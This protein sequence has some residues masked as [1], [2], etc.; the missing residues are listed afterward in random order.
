MR[1]AQ[2]ARI[3]LG[4]AGNRVLVRWRVWSHVGRGYRPAAQCCGSFLDA[5][6]AGRTAELG[7]V[8]SLD[9]TTLRGDILDPRR[10]AERFRAP[11][12]MIGPAGRESHLTQHDAEKDW[13]IAGPRPDG[14]GFQL[15]DRARESADLH[16]M[17]PFARRF[18]PLSPRAG[19]QERRRRGATD[20][21]SAER[22]IGDC[23]ASSAARAAVR[24]AVPCPS[25]NQSYTGRNT[26]CASG[27]R[28]V[29]ASRFASAIA[30]RSSNDFACWS[31]AYAIAFRNR[32]RR[33][34]YRRRCAAARLW[35]GAARRCS[36][37]RACARRAPGPRRRPRAPHRCVRQTAGDPRA[38]R[39]T[40]SVPARCQW[41]AAPPGCP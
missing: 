19:R 15:R 27:R 7:E 2:G 20:G 40:R 6:P 32:L 29:D 13:R 39:E 8:T 36:R 18:D 12:R 31:Q 24:S 22:R 33:A 21:A 30:A 11:S 23:S 35:H 9:V 34:P 28:P 25:L 1:T 4:H 26:A 10:S 37:L 5:H 16:G 14:R 38:R 3:S 41:P 17:A